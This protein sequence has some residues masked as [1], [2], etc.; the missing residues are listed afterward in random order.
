MCTSCHH[1]QVC[2]IQNMD[3]ESLELEY[4]KSCSWVKIEDLVGFNE[5]DT[6]SWMTKKQLSLIPLSRADLIDQA[7]P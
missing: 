5:R 1:N 7:V 6:Y 2:I 4:D 3:D